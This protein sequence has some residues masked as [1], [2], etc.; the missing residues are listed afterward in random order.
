MF[1]T[2]QLISRKRILTSS[3]HYSRP[4]QGGRP[5]YHNKDTLMS[6]L[7]ILFKKL[8]W[9]H[10]EYWYGSLMDWINED[11]DKIYWNQLIQCLLHQIEKL[12]ACTESC[13]RQRQSIRNQ[14]QENSAPPPT[15]PSNR[16]KEP[17]PPFSPPWPCNRVP[18]LSMRIKRQKHQ[19]RL[20][21]W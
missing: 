20:Y 3:Y 16:W 7:C 15:F 11:S 8:H 14:T 19:I 4:E 12:P 1:N 21:Y 2:Y 17:P 9:F 13:N 18:P 6:N 10:I 5:Q